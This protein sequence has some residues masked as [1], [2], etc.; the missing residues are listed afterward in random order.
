MTAGGTARDRKEMESG[1]AALRR[2]VAELSARLDEAEATLSAIRGGEVDAVVVSTPAGESVYTL[3][4]ADHAYRIFLEDM[5]DGAV[6]LTQEGLILYANRRFAEIAGAPFEHV[7]GSAFFRFLS[8]S[9]ADELRGSLAGAGTAGIRDEAS[10]ETPHGRIPVL[11][12]VNPLPESDPPAVCMVVTDLTERERAHQAVAESERRF[13]FLVDNSLVG[14]F[15]AT[16]GRIVFANAE[17]QRIFG[18]VPIPASV[19][20]LPDIGPQDREKFERLC[21]AATVTASGMMET[22]IR[23]YPE[24]HGEET[25]TPLWAHC[26]A[27]PIEYQGKNAVLV[28]MVDVT[29]TR[30]ME[31]IAILQEKMASLGQATA[32]IA[33]NI[34]NPLSGINI[35]ISMMKSLLDDAAGLDA[36]TKKAVD[37]MIETLLQTS[38]RI[39][40]VIQQVLDFARS[41]P[42]AIALVHVR[43]ALRQAVELCRMQARKS[44]VVLVMDVPEGLPPC[45]IGA[46]LL[47][48]VF[49]NVISNA[50]RALENHAGERKIAINA[51]YSDGSVVVRIADSGP[52]VPEKIRAKI[53]EPFFTTHEQGTG[54]GLAFSRRVLESV[55][56]RIDVGVSALLGG[57]EFR[58]RIPAGDRRKS[59][60]KG[61]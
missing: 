28:N 47:E 21:D 24:S 33:H 50:V 45:Y 61:N 57:A 34:R 38:A 20:E 43:D 44:N 18:H 22:E 48:Q 53:F 40:S 49:M 58:I 42:L 9:D 19:Q 23:F 52:G 2:R 3:K 26:R 51:G 16:E 30:E 15:I 36:Q 10:F 4:G 17:Q 12:S 8:P 27:A 54:I 46:G 1:A 35:Y 11:L 56:G 41:S 31:Q 5:G 32:G 13:R 7:V 25:K 60:R 14:F 37:E 59:P 29:R 6:I 55:G 39:T